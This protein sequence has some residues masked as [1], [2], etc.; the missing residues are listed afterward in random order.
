MSLLLWPI[1]VVF[2]LCS[3]PVILLA[4]WCLSA[5]PHILKSCWKYLNSNAAFPFKTY[6]VNSVQ[7]SGRGDKP[8]TWDQGGVKIKLWRVHLEPTQK[9]DFVIF[10][11]DRWVYRKFFRNHSVFVFNS[12]VSHTSKV[13]QADGFL[14]CKVGISPKLVRDLLSLT[15]GGAGR[16][17]VLGGVWLPLTQPLLTFNLPAYCVPGARWLWS[18]PL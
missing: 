13:W 8:V 10:G 17:Q 18:L 16:T 2:W 3:S 15:G 14:I 11:L 1:K 9:G 5:L 7:M 4:D 6:R 12:F